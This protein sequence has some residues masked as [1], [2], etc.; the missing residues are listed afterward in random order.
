MDGPRKGRG[1]KWRRNEMKRF[2]AAFLDR[3][4]LGLLA[5]GLFKPVFG[6]GPDD[7]L[8]IVGAIAATIAL[9]GCAIYLLSTLEDE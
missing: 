6:P 4:A 9:E 3:A 2:G 1:M 8:L 5:A 7:V